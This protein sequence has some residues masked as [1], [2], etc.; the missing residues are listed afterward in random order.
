[1]TPLNFSNLRAGRDDSATRAAAMASAPA[2]LAERASRS[3]SSR[4]GARR[5]H[6]SESGARTDLE[7]PRMTAPHRTATP[8]ATLTA[9]LPAKTAGSGGRRL[10]FLLCV[11]KHRARVNAGGQNG[12]RDLTKALDAGAVRQG[13][14]QAASEPSQARG[15]TVRRGVG[16]RAQSKRP[17]E[18]GRLQKKLRP[19]SPAGGPN[20]RSASAA[21][22]TKDSNATGRGRD[23]QESAPGGIRT[24]DLHLSQ[25][26]ALSTE[27]RGRRRFRGTQSLA[28]AATPPTQLADFASTRGWS[29][30]RS[31]FSRVVTPPI[32]APCFE[33]THPPEPSA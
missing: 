12:R 30:K 4:S 32:L 20:P 21:P 2:S 5:S 18:A 11:A 17:A 22:L 16:E 1:M 27:L 28:A 31:N 26:R 7:V 15:A 9:H 23:R 14:A 8:F 6:L 25:R 13:E 10:P 3:D 29:I 24:R 33:A 19:R